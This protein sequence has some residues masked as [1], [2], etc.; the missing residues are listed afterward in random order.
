M[1]HLQR[2]PIIYL[3]YSIFQYHSH[4]SVFSTQG[5]LGYACSKWDLVD[6][7]EDH[8]SVAEHLILSCLCP[9]RILLE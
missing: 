7:N 4:L 6:R 3:E 9:Y 5:V 1:F 8:F 2:H